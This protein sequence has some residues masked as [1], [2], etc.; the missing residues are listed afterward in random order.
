MNLTAKATCV[1]N[2]EIMPFV[3]LIKSKAYFKLFQV[4]FK[5]RREGKTDYF[6]TTCGPRQEQ[7]QY[8]KA[9]SGKFIDHN[10]LYFFKMLV[11]WNTKNRLRLKAILISIKRIR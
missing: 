11:H 7:I 4:K 1:K 2:T 3:K 5:R 6:T 9:K 10:Y 8:S